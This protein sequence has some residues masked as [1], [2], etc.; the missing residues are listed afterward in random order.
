MNKISWINLLNK[1]LFIILKQ[2]F[3]SSRIVPC[4]E[5]RP[6]SLIPSSYVTHLWYRVPQSPECPPL[7]SAVSGDHSAALFDCTH[8][9]VNGCESPPDIETGSSKIVSA[10]K[11]SWSANSESYRE[12]VSVCVEEHQFSESIQ[13]LF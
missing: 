9:P 11:H 13:I 3:S 4:S 10:R 5:A 8:T 7:V 6:L 1:M 12:N 2:L